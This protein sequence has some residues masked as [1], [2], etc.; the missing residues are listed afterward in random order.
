MTNASIAGA[1]LGAPVKADPYSNSQSIEFRF[2]ARRFAHVQRLIETI[3]SERGRADIIDLGGTETYWRIGADFIRANRHRL[4]ITLVNPDPQAIQDREVFSFREGSATD[5]A[6]YADRSFD[7]VHSNSVIEHVGDWRD[8]E[9]FAANARRLA[10]RYYIQTPNYWFPYEPHFRCPGFQYLPA[11]A[12]ARLIMR[13]SLGFFRRIAE[14]AEADDIIRHHR[15]LSTREMAAL[16][17]DGHVFH[18][19]AFGLNKS[20]IATRDAAGSGG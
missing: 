9:D 19:K 5:R 13:F 11:A 1:T 12:R 2:R 14:R 20:V 8:F 3:L 16:F 17:P 7:L 6:L 18:E 10:P 15:L 4:S